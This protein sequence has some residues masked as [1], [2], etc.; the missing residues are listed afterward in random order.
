MI[1]K[2]VIF[3]IKAVVARKW[4]WEQISKGNPSSDR[5]AVD[6]WSQVH[7]CSRREGGAAEGGSEAEGEEKEMGGRGKRKV[8]VYLYVNDRRCG[9]RLLVY[10]WSSFTMPAIDNFLKS[11]TGIVNDDHWPVVKRTSFIIFLKPVLN[12]VFFI[13]KTLFISKTSDQQT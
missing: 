12:S 7:P 11:I 8:V 13:P 9:Q 10:Q 3:V 5:R 6:W 2:L 1:I 4:E